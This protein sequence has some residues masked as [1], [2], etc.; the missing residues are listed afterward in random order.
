M[1]YTKI[2]T[3]WAVAHTLKMNNPQKP[4]KGE[5]FARLLNINKF[6]MRKLGNKLK[7]QLS[8]LYAGFRRRK[9]IKADGRSPFKF[10]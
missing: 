8:E 2:I 7:D 5:A 1:L 6:S 10:T 4:F 3:A 9:F